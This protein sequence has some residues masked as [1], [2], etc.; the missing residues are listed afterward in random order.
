MQETSRG[1][2]R[3]I[4]LSDKVI[5]SGVV[6]HAILLVA[7]WYAAIRAGIDVPLISGRP[8]LLLVWAWL[9]WPIYI[10]ARWRVSKLTVGALLLGAAIMVPALPTA[11]AFT[12]W[13]IGGFAP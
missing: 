4:R 1:A 5:A 10:F 11:Y 9:A 12:A 13:S 6:V 8:W 3:T 7:C 2:P